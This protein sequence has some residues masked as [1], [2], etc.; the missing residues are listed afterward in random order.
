MAASKPGR[1]AAYAAGALALAMAVAGCKPVGPNYQ[2]PVYVTPP[3]YKETGASNVTVPPPPPPSG[4]GWQPANPSDGM[5]KGKWWEIYNDP[6]LNKLEERIA[7]VNQGL[8][9]ALETYLA[10]REQVKI[11]RAAFYPTLSAG[12]GFTHDKLSGHRPLL[13]PGENSINQYNDLTLEGQASWEPDFWGGIRR[14][15]EGARAAAQ[16]SNADMANVALSLESEMAE[17]YFELRGLDL[18]TQLLTSDINDLQNQLDLTRTR[19][20]GGVATEVDVAQAQT[21]LDTDA[22]P[23]HRRRRRARRV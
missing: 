12:P 4:G 20:K 13:I 14:A 17:D 8:H 6:Q 1:K 18:Q 21:Q 5:L 23:A 3:I 11:A 15:V 7:A 22:R 19:L 10:A 9:Q 16:A 2:R